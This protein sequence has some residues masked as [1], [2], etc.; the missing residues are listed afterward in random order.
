M[1]WNNPGPPGPQGPAGA[2]GP[3]G[4]QGPPGV[5][6][7]QTPTPI[8]TGVI[9]AGNLGAIDMPCP[10]GETAISGGYIVPYTATVLESHPLPDNAGPWR[11]TA[12]FPSVSGTITAYV[13]CAQVTAA[14]ARATKVKGVVHTTR[15]PFA[16]RPAA[17]R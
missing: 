11:V 17:G 15:L 10:D 2:Q 12:A 6:E 16:P 14:A 9:P 8:T 5:S 13:Q 7:F 4:P 1:S 3:A